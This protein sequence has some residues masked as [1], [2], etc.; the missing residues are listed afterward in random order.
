MAIALILA[1]L[2]SF[3]PA[4]VISS[5]AWPGTNTSAI[6]PETG[7]ATG[8]ASVPVR[9]YLYDGG[10]V[11][12]G[13]SSSGGGSSD[14]YYYDDDDDDDYNPPTTKPD[15]K[16]STST[17]S[18]SGGGGG[19][20]SGGGSS[21]SG[22]VIYACN[23]VH[24]C[25][26]PWYF[27]P[28]M[29]QVDIYNNWPGSNSLWTP[30]YDELP[31]G[32][33][34][35]IIKKAKIAYLY[36]GFADVDHKSVKVNT[37]FKANRALE[38]LGYD[39]VWQ[40][41]ETYHWNTDQSPAML[42]PH[43][44][45][46][47]L[48][49]EVDANGN[50]VQVNP[51][52]V[53]KHYIN[54]GW[55]I[56]QTYRAVG[57]ELY[58]VYVVS[59]TGA[60]YPG[61][62]M[63]A[64]EIGMHPI[65]E[66][67]GGLPID[68]ETFGA[69]TF[70]NWNNT[71]VATRTSIDQYAQQWESDKL[72]GLMSF[73]TVQDVM[74]NMVDANEVQNITVAQFCELVATLMQIYGEPVLNTQ[75]E[76]LLLQAYGQDI[77][78]YLNPNQ[79][80]A[81]KYLMAR[82]IVRDVTNWQDAIEFEQAIDILMRVKDKDSRYTFKEITL[83][84]DVDLL[85]QGYYPVE[86]SNQTNP[87]Q[88]VQTVGPEVDTDRF[89]ILLRVD[90]GDGSIETPYAFKSTQ[91]LLSVPY[92]AEWDSAGSGGTHPELKPDGTDT[93]QVANPL[94]NSSY[95]GL[96]S[97]TNTE[98]VYMGQFYWFQVPRS[99][100][101]DEVYINSTVSTDVPFGY[102]VRGGNRGGIFEA[103]G[104][105]NAI[106]FQHKMSFDEAKVDSYYM[107]EERF[108]KAA[109]TATSKT[110]NIE[111]SNYGFELV[112]PTDMADKFKW[113]DANGDVHTLQEITQ[114]GFSISG[115][116]VKKD[117]RWKTFDGFYLGYL[118]K[119]E[120][121]KGYSYFDLIGCYNQSAALAAFTWEGDGS[122]PMQAFSA[123]CKGN[124]SYLVS[125]SY[126][127]DLGIALHPTRI[128]EHSYYFS[129]KST[130]SGFYVYT[131][132]YINQ[133]TVTPTVTRGSQVTIYPEGTL[134]LKEYNNGVYVDWQAVQGSSSEIS[135]R[136]S[137]S[138]GVVSLSAATGNSCFAGSPRS[139]HVKGSSTIFSTYGPQAAE[140][141]LVTQIGSGAA[142]GTYLYT[143]VSYALANY[144]TIVD[145]RTG[146]SPS[147][148]CI[149]A[150]LTSESSDRDYTP[151]EADIAAQFGLQMKSK[152]TKLHFAEMHP[153][154][155][156]HV[157]TDNPTLLDWDKAPADELIYY[158][159]EQN[160][161]LLRIPDNPS[162]TTMADLLAKVKSYTGASK[163]DADVE[164]LH[165]IRPSSGTSA[166][167]YDQA[168]F[169]KDINYNL[170][171]NNEAIGY[172]AEV[173]SYTGTDGKTKYS[174]ASIAQTTKPWFGEG[175]APSLSDSTDWVHTYPTD[176]W[177]A[178]TGTLMFTPAVVGLPVLLCKNQITQQIS[179]RET[180]SV[181]Y[182]CGTAKI[183]AGVQRIPGQSLVQDDGAADYNRDA[184]LLHTNG[185]YVVVGFLT[186]QLTDVPS[187]ALAI[188]T[189]EEGASARRPAW[190]DELG[191]SPVFDWLEFIT[192]AKLED[193]DDL[194][195]I[196]ILAALAFIPRFFM[197][198]FL[199]LIALALIAD[200]KV[201]QMFCDQV[202]DP[203][204]F[205]SAG[206]QNVHTIKVKSLVIWSTIALGL[207]GI[208]Q[209]GLILQIM[210]WIARAVVGI[211]GRR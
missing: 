97:L 134:L 121:S 35:Q 210:G 29:G 96:V 158:I 3:I 175:T 176:R 120:G 131:D 102:T 171:V 165:G 59:N 206:R 164:L 154:A 17:G 149:T 193:A 203:Y 180:S 74:G 115:T 95:C 132:I 15:T 69:D 130:V 147:V 60:G 169:L 47:Y 46:S 172:I 105:G 67:V 142:G 111:E 30:Y 160:A 124:S 195:T 178:Q 205:L 85:S 112:I 128:S 188:Q 43:Y 126:L 143:P 162:A 200:V 76:Y 150:W 50:F 135:V 89:D 204:K 23:C 140:E 144:V 7:G 27:S 155:I 41:G 192:N 179:L 187:S 61:G 63:T 84:A 106:T 6:S 12:S 151:V 208:F 189:P 9:Y 26:H 117:N 68:R 125:I 34:G 104:G 56:M 113:K 198:L 101:Y 48:D 78:Y 129:L 184:I 66:Q 146:V 42:T 152:R 11:S 207:F 161:V 123:F 116:D 39:T 174:W 185:D 40:A 65:L 99:W 28:K 54:T 51:E 110:A 73:Q 33:S 21:S 136:Q 93:N 199:I 55:A 100:S 2:L 177:G 57:V 107:D 122:K 32:T 191:S 25:E 53:P 168:A 77:P 8:Q 186:P 52:T 75:E 24:I 196:L 18:G 19:G 145:K 37:A 13:G 197:A 5:F 62:T 103:S 38:I 182:Y 159:P 170:S 138:D 157:S 181:T 49:P 44:W 1:T 94:A 20:D 109:E 127:Q 163:A 201:W 133:S 190:G 211:L 209:N 16:P 92:V 98:G 64:E 90:A 81:A 36:T 72:N 141:M 167:A 108:K 4:I 10:G 87:M 91:A 79:V 139:A 137:D 148:Y 166:G 114:S 153:T 58:T 119:A 156:V 183:S 45:P 80:E 70:K 202:F 118:K 88:A 31:A 83:T 22:D 173:S 194:L 14:D 71:I 86:V 82:G